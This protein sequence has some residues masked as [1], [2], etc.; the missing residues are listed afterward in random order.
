[1]IEK[2]KFHELWEYC[3]TVR[4]GQIFVKITIH[5]GEATDIEE[6]SPPL[7]KFRVKRNFQEIAKKTLTN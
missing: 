3:Q 6:I 7:R 4:F 1:M 5:Q 2:E